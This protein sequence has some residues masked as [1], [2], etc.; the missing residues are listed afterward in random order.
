MSER[1]SAP[2]EFVMVSALLVTMVLGLMQVIL[3]VHVR[4]TLLSAA[5]E[6]ARQAALADVSAAGATAVTRALVEAS[7]SP[8]Y[9]EDISVQR[10]QTLGVPTALVIITAPVPALG[11]WTV[12]GEMVVRAHAPLEFAR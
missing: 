9:A 12:G 3:V 2:A 6:G 1:G 5:T 11:L 8:S 7:L 4:H 10:S